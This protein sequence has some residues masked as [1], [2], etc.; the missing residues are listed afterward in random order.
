MTSDIHPLS[1]PQR[2]ARTARG[3]RHRRDATVAAGGGARDEDRDARRRRRSSGRRS[4]SC[5]RSIANRSR[6]RTRR[7]RPTTSRSSSRRMPSSTVCRQSGAWPASNRDVRARTGNG[8]GAGGG[9]HTGCAGAVDVVRQRRPA[10][11]AG[12]SPTSPASASSS[13]AAKAAAN[14]S[15]ARCATRGAVVDHVPCYRRVAPQT[16]ADGLV[17]AMR[18][19]RAHALTLTSSEGLDNLVARVGHRPDV[20]WWR[21]LPVFAAHPRIAER[22][23]EHGLRADRNRGR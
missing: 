19:G 15:A 9:R 7:C 8:R 4:S 13:F 14:F 20:R 21:R 18:E 17:E 10:R 16:G 23:R 12:S 5:R 1:P 3:H 11:A 22:A 2:R 6:A